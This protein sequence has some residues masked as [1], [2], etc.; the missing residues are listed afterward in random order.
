MR[1]GIKIIICEDTPNWWQMNGNINSKIRPALTIIS[2]CLYQLH[3]VLS[4][5]KVFNQIPQ[6]TEKRLFHGKN[7]NKRP[8]NQLYLQNNS[9]ALCNYVR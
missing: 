4:T 5:A 8:N 1:K 7:D 2:A 6:F 3:N 9:S